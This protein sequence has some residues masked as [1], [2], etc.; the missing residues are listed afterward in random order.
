MYYMT[1]TMASLTTTPTTP[2]T[3]SVES[4]TSTSVSTPTTE[5]VLLTRRQRKRRRQKKN[6][7]TQLPVEDTINNKIDSKFQKLQ[8][9]KAIDELVEYASQMYK[10]VKDTVKSMPDFINWQD[11]KKLSFFRDTLKYKDFMAEYPVVSRYMVCMGQYKNSAFRKFLNKTRMTKH[12][13]PAKREKGYMRD[14]WLQRQADYVKY[15]WIAC[16]KG[17]YNHAEAKSIWTQAYQSLKGEMD[18]FKDKYEELK[19]STKEE[20]KKLDADNAREL[21]G[22]LIEGKQ[23]LPDS[24]ALKLK[25]KLLDLAYKRRMSNALADMMTKV[26]RM[27]P[28]SQGRGTGEEIDEQER[29]RNTITMIEHVDADRIDEI[30]QH[31]LLDEKTASRLPGYGDASAVPLQ[32]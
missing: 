13:P 6:K 17:P 4:T 26:P 22:R 20:K 25:E 28:S 19:K 8:D 32:V 12:P 18:D 1:D 14:Q 2:T 3:S 16:K 30:P 15:L 21:L 29:K 5:P 11:K 9:G 23:Q 27:E 10:V 31:M 24:N 7:K